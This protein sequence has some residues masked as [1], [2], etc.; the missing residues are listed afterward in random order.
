VK[1]HAQ[2]HHR[3]HCEDSGSRGDQHGH[4]QAKRDDL[5]QVGS[6]FPISPHVRVGKRCARQGLD[7]KQE[8]Q[9]NRAI[10]ISIARTLRA[11]PL[12]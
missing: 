10:N 1:T 6:E 3:H 7:R 5:E 4:D 8:Q 12:L 2:R 9:Q 11:E